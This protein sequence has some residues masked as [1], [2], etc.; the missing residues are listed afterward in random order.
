LESGLDKIEEKLREELL[1]ELETMED[2]AAR[3]ISDWLEGKYIV[4]S[5]C[6]TD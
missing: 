4:G 1:K 2:A 6:L 5:E 3:E